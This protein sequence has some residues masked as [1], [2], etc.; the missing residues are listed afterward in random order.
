M[1]TG[2]RRASQRV[3]RVRRQMRAHPMEAH[4]FTFRFYGPDDR[5]TDRLAAV[6]VRGKMGQT[7]A[8]PAAY[9][10]ARTVAP[11]PFCIDIQTYP[12]RVLPERTEQLDRLCAQHTGFRCFLDLLVAVAGY[13]PSIRLDVM[14]RDGVVLARAYDRAQERLGDPRRAFIT[15]K[16]AIGRNESMEK[17]GGREAA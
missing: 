15:G 9:E 6:V 7:G 5:R 12:S 4:V 3:V 8:I 17:E 10:K 16:V 13:R 11:G 14:G 1:T 2:R